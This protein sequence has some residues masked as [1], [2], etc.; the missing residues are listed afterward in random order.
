M[1]DSAELRT[2]I[3]AAI[4]A[5]MKDKDKLRVSTLRLVMAAVKDRDIAARAE[6]RCDGINTEEILS[7]LVKMLKQRN[8]SAKTY[9]DNGRPELAEREREEIEII[10]EFMPTP[11]SD[12]EMKTI[13]S[14]LITD[15]GATCLKDM[16]K[17]MGKLKSGYAGRV[18]MGKAGAVVKEHLCS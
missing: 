3:T 10:R 14:G 15:S 4:K 16:G 13:I 9:E 6:D 18:D 8:E 5:A 11:L 12:D 17:I 7:L 2:R 1:T